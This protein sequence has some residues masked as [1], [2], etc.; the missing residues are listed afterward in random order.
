MAWLFLFTECLS[1]INQQMSRHLVS[2]WNVSTKS[3]WQPS[4]SDNTQKIIEIQKI[5]KNILNERIIN[6]EK[7]IGSESETLIWPLEE[8]ARLQRWRLASIV[9]PEWKRPTQDQK[10]VTEVLWFSRTKIES[11]WRDLRLCPKNNLVMSFWQNVTFSAK[12]KKHMHLQHFI[13]EYDTK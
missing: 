2:N 9:P 1:P 6:M 4:V 7:H 13:Q 10:T 12:L 11:F 3:T 5:Y 8:V